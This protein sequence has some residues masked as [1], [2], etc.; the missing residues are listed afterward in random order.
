MLRVDNPQDVEILSSFPGNGET[1]LAKDWLELR[2][3]G[4]KYFR[5]DEWNKAIEYYTRCIDLALS[6]DNIEQQVPSA[7][8]VQE[9]VSGVC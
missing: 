7:S 9:K 2:N 1:S 5:D 6:H 8:N 4:N 3:E